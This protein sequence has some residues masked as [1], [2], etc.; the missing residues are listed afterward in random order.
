MTAYEKVIMQKQVSRGI[1]YR[2]TE[3]PEHDPV[4]CILMPCASRHVED[5][6]TN[7]FTTLTV[8]SI[9]YNLTS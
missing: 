1:K 5:G 2:I 9:Q 7:G 8:Y 3:R 4:I 6:V